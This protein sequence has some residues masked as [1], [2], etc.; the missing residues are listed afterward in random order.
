MYASARTAQLRAVRFP[1]ETS[2]TP[3]LFPPL[4]LSA[5]AS[6]R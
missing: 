5:I 3:Q 4:I 1:P 6:I 2:G